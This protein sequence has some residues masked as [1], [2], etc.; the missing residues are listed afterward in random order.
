MSKHDFDFFVGRWRTENRRRSDTGEWQEFAATN[1]V[2]MH[3]DNLVQFDRYDAPDFPGR[4]HVKAVTVRAYDS[5]T[6]QW[7][8]VWLSNYAP[9]DHRPLV[10]AWDG[11]EAVFRQSIETPDGRP[12]DIRFNWS[13]RDPD[14]PRWEQH[15]SFDRGSTW[16][17]NW[18]MDFSRI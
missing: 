6:G 9:P 2:E 3:V 11:D 5:G 10:G 13:R 4:G 12:W 16:E 15:F 14:H 7:S 8:I 17:F 18:S 1:T